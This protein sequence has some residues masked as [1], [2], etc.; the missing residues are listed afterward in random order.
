MLDSKKDIDKNSA[1]RCL[2]LLTNQNKNYWQPILNNMG[3]EKL[4][5][6]LR[7]YCL[8]FAPKAKK[9]AVQ[10]ESDL[11]DSSKQQRYLDVLSVLCNIS[12]RTEIKQCLNQLKD[13]CDI[14]IKILM[15]TNNED[16]KSRVAILIADIASYEVANKDVLADNGCL[17]K[18]IDLLESESED[19]LVNAVN[20]LEILCKDNV[21]NQDH[22]CKHGVLENLVDLLALNSGNNV[23]K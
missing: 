19:V 10:D 18:L 22:C 6:L 9:V 2:Q 12:E 13:V 20:A 3:I 8:S 1:V 15:H 5:A 7:E 17:T 16:M 14:L 23:T 4:M 11:E 21:K